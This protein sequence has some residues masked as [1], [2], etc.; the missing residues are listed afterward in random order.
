M[1]HLPIHHG[2]LIFS[3]LGE[4]SE[5]LKYFACSQSLWSLLH[6]AMLLGL[7]LQ[8]MFGVLLP[9]LSSG[10]ALRKFNCHRIGHQTFL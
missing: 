2:F 9:F 1:L 5:F 7:M 10:T 6:W 3:V 4:S 8:V